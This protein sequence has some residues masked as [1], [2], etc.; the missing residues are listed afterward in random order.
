MAEQFSESVEIL[1]SAS[2]VT[3]TLDG[4][5]A[6]ITAGGNGQDGGSP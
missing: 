5:R 2:D 4:D 3:I 6:D 1:N